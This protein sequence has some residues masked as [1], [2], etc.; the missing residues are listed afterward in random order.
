MKGLFFLRVVKPVICFA[1]GSSMLGSGISLCVFYKVSHRTNSSI[2]A[3]NVFI[4]I[5]SILKMKVTS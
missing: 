2:Q 3:S 4:G 1:F 5:D